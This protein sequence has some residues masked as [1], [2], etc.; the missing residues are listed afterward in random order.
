MLDFDM[1]NR[2][3]NI[4][5][6]QMEVDAVDDEDYDFDAFQRASSMYPSS[7][8]QGTRPNHLSSS[9]AGKRKNNL[10]DFIQVTPRGRP[11]QSK[12]QAQQHG[13]PGTQHTS[14]ANTSANTLRAP[15]GP[16]FSTYKY[17]QT[18]KKTSS[19]TSS[20]TDALGCCSD[21]H[22]HGP[23]VSIAASQP[24]GTTYTATDNMHVMSEKV[25][26]LLFETKR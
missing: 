20:S 19:N 10:D 11:A 6:E 2:G 12:P 4:G 8:K 5:P 14:N 3:G 21:Q 13:T 23:T 25:P 7:G 1:P 22:K 17:K 15:I 9:A 26:P 16:S 24:P 18:A